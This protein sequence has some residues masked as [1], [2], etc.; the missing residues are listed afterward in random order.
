MVTV[1]TKLLDLV[2]AI[3][4]DGAVDGRVGT[5]YSQLLKAYGGSPPYTWAISTGS[6]SL[7]PGIALTNAGSVWQL[8]GAPTLSGTFPFTVRLTDQ[9]LGNQS[10]AMSIIVY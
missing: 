9:V 3:A 6:A 8:S 2:L 1:D 5:A 4:T 7:P 10:L